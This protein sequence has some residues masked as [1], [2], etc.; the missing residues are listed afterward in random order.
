MEINEQRFI[1]PY[2]I[3][4]TFLDIIYFNESNNEYNKF[5]QSLDIEI[6]G[7]IRNYMA[8]SDFIYLSEKVCII[9]DDFDFFKID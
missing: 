2:D 8:Y 7:R 9:F 1:T 5:G 6:N 3:H 4:S